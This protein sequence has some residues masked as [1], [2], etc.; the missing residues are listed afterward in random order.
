MTH[1]QT[2][3][4]FPN[5]A[6]GYIRVSTEKQNVGDQALERQ[7]EKIRKFCAERGLRLAAV[8]EDVGSAADK[9]SLSRRTGLQDA[10]AYA[11]REGA[12][13]IV[14]E[15]TRL[16][17]NVEV[18]TKWLESVTVP[19]LSVRDGIALSHPA[20]LDAVRVGELDVTQRKA[21]TSN[22]LI[23]KSLAGQ[24]LGSPVDKSAANKASAL[25]RL[26]RS[27]GI[28]DTIALILLEDPAYGD[29]SHRAFSDLLNRRNV[30]TGWSRPWTAAGVKRSRGLAEQRVIEWQ[31]FENE[32]G[33][34]S[35]TVKPSI[36]AQPHPVVVSDIDEEAEMKKLDHFGMF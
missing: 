23:Q 1:T 5:A 3:T 6:V 35:P 18:A 2:L 25:A 31:G 34:G 17:R 16:A 33:C 29:L 9:H 21:A 4:D 10:F 20:V 15:P 13:L 7:A 8:Y 24:L 26:R 36:S 19:V 30:L 22:V 32:K 28:I 27:E 11:Q 12:C 14:T